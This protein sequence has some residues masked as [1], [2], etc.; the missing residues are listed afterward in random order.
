MWCDQPRERARRDWRA[1][2]QAVS[3]DEDTAKAVALAGSDPDGDALSFTITEQ[4]RHGV[5]TGAAPN[6]T[7][8]PDAD[9]NGSDSFSYKVGDGILESAVV[10][11]TIEVLPVNDAPVATEQVLVTTQGVPLTF[12]LDVTDADGDALLFTI[13]TPPAHGTLSDSLP[14]AIYTP[15]PGFAG[16]DSFTYAVSDG[17]A[18]VSGVQVSIEVAASEPSLHRLYVPHIKR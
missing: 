2:G 3:T 10:T 14:N 17:T 13:L 9:Y 6:L 18:V 12:T 1:H 7:Y 8:T 5:L 15:D 16:S 11:V 4:P